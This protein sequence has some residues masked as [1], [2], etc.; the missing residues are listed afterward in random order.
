MIRRLVGV[1]HVADF[2]SI[3]DADARAA[4]ERRALRFARECL[5]G[6]LRGSLL[7]DFAAAAEEALRSE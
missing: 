2:E 3:E 5:C 6:S 7:Q 1:A 4:C